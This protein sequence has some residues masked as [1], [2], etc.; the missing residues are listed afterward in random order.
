MIAMEVIPGPRRNDATVFQQPR[1]GADLAGDQ[2]VNFVMNWTDM[3]VSQ[4]KARTRA[5]LK[6]TTIH[7][8]ADPVATPT[9]DAPPG[10]PR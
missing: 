5:R 2:P 4:V 9:R 7:A 8:E 10:T 6:L 1:T 3:N